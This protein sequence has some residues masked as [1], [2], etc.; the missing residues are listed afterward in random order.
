MS[1]DMRDGIQTTLECYD[2]CTEGVAYCAD[3]GGQHIEPAHL[4]ALLDCAEIC[5]AAAGFI[6]RASDL[7]TTVCDAC[8]AACEH[9]ATSCDQL[10]DDNFMPQC[11]EVC[12][13]CAQACRRMAGVQA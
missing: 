2:I 7:H 3:R 10:S 11:A 6:L 12:R 8:A 4:K 1:E 9:C 13:R 5:K